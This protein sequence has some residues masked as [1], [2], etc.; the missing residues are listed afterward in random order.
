MTANIF[1]ILRVRHPML[2]TRGARTGF[3]S[4]VIFMGCCKNSSANP[5]GAATKRAGPHEP[6]LRDAYGGSG[7]SC[8]EIG[9]ERAGGMDADW[10]DE[11]ATHVPLGLRRIPCDQGK[12]QGLFGFLAISAPFSVV[13]TE[14]C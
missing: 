9:P 12:H 7:V 10:A 3:L 6:A 11:T 5:P 1:L 14:I 13:P 8:Q 2:R 4:I